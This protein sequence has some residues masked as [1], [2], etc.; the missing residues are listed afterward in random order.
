[1]CDGAAAACAPSCLTNSAWGGRANGSYV[2]RSRQVTDTARPL[3]FLKDDERGVCEKLIRFESFL[4]PSLSNPSLQYVVAY[5]PPPAVRST[6]LI[7]A[8]SKSCPNLGFIFAYGHF[9]RDI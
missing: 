2:P 1:M 3:N 7:K 9:A 4:N 5:S 8:I 6:G